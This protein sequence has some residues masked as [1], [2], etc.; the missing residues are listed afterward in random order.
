MNQ[1]FPRD[2]TLSSK[3]QL[4]IPHKPGLQLTPHSRGHFKCHPSDGSSVITITEKNPCTFEAGQKNIKPAVLSS[5][6]TRGDDIKTEIKQLH[7][8]RG[9]QKQSCRP[10][11]GET[12]AATVQ[13][14]LSSAGRNP[15]VPQSS[16]QSRAVMETH[17]SNSPASMRQVKKTGPGKPNTNSRVR[18]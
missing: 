14:V 15:I 18:E 3:F 12:R 1:F 17:P 13:A 11:D 16:K 9:Q 6:F 4:Y 7:T 8:C 10:K 2:H 5:L